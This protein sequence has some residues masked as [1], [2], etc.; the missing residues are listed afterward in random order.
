M[1]RPVAEHAEEPEQQHDHKDRTQPDAMRP[2]RRLIH[3]PAKTGDGN[4]DQDDEKN[5][6]AEI[7]A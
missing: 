5:N 7:V 4:D 1:E 6:H 3:T 2:I